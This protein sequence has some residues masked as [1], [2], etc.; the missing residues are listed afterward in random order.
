MRFNSVDMVINYNCDRYH[1][2]AHD[3]VENQRE[4]ERERV[5]TY[6]RMALDPVDDGVVSTHSDH[7]C[8]IVLN[9]SWRGIFVGRGQSFLLIQ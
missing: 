9:K 2:H 5:I 7:G 3:T 6:P 1:L 4:R 8:D